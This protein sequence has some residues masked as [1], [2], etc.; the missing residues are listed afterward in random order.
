[1]ETDV[2]EHLRHTTTHVTHLGSHTGNVGDNA[3]HRVMRRLLDPDGHFLWIDE[4]VRNYYFNARE[5]AFDASFAGR[6]N[7]A[8]ALLVGGGAFLAPEFPA[9]ASG[10][11][12]DIS[13]VVIDQ[14][15][16]PVS[17]SAVGYLTFRETSEVARQRLRRWVESVVERG[18]EIQLRD[19]GSCEAF[20]RDIGPLDE[21]GIGRVPDPG[22][23]IRDEDRDTPPHGLPSEY[24]AVNLAGDSLERRH[25][26]SAAL[27]DFLGTVL[28]MISS[29]PC[30]VVL[31]PHVLADMDIIG[32]LVSAAGSDWHVRKKLW[33][34]PLLH[35]EDGSRRTF[36]VYA[37]ARAVLANR[38]HAVACNLSLAV[39]VRAFVNAA[40]VDGMLRQLGLEEVGLPARAA[41]PEILSLLL[42]EPSSLADARASAV[43]KA[44]KELALH[45]H[46]L[47]SRLSST[48][49]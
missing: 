16:R 43:A 37:G 18:V 8:D 39:P 23:G 28:Q 1:M 19:D 26:T 29:A 11:T 9:S 14:I 13:L 47:R 12:L 42:E 40:N 35:G 46:R 17:I 34:A 15:A 41:G 25:A 48:T 3:S 22:L 10:T 30:P 27:D 5:R 44:T 20:S 7:R 45:A 21:L 32:R 2:P 36:G 6:V 49:G 38:F 4:E 31:V 24:I 33:V